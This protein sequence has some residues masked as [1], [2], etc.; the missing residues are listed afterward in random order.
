LNRLRRVAFYEG[1]SFLV[2]LGIAMPLKYLA[3]MPMAVRIAGSIHGGLFI[4][5]LA[6]LAHTAR[7]RD[8]SVDRISGALLASVVPF[9]TFVLD[10]HLQR[11]AAAAT[12]SS[13]GLE[14]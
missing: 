8:W 13:G 5:F 6:A 14:T 11:E 2:L 4:L 10:R 3:G 9:G 12:T 1:V 7:R